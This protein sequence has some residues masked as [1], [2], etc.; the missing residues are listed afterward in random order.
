MSSTPNRA[1]QRAARAL[2]N[3]EGIRYTT[4][5]RRVTDEDRRRTQIDA[6]VTAVRAITDEAWKPVEA[7]FWA[8]GTGPVADQITAADSLAD[9]VADRLRITP[10]F[11]AF[12]RALWDVSQRAGLGSGVDARPRRYL[13]EYALL[14]IFAADLTSPAQRATLLAP[15][16]ATGAVLPQGSEGAAP[17]EMGFGSTGCHHLLD[18]QWHRHPNDEACSDALARFRA[19][20]HDDA[21]EPRMETSSGFAHNDRS[22]CRTCAAPIKHLARWDYTG[23]ESDDWRDSYVL[24]DAW[25]V[26]QVHPVD[27]HDAAPLGV[28]DRVKFA[29]DRRW[30]TVRARDGQ[31]V[32][33]TRSGDF[34]RG[35]RYTII[36]W[37]AQRRGPHD[38][39]LGP[40]AAT[41]EDCQHLLTGL[42]CGDL[43]LSERRSVPLDITA[44]AP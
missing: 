44:V 11:A 13:T 20:S 23:A 14:T 3:A 32:V 4:A 17:V 9:A 27:G 16:R 5:L 7:A 38:R 33:A 34:G 43:A 2:A 19:A 6:L 10:A 15:L 29:G 8:G 30:W 1:R 36:D 39:P 18:G 42:A 37:A 21:P 31:R 22:V 26:H 40:G 12:E 25:W 28:R 35:D 41:D 24:N